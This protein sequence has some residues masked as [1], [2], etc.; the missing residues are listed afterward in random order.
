MPEDQGKP[1]KVHWEIPPDTVAQY[2]NN[3][4][5]QHSDDTF[6]LSFWQIQQPIILGT[7]EERKEQVDKID[8]TNARFVTQIAMSPAQMAQLVKGLQENLEKYLKAFGWPS[9]QQPV[10]K[11]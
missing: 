7:P 1:V 6:F 9:Q 2:V 8:S 3:F 10:K 4:V 5:V 11:E